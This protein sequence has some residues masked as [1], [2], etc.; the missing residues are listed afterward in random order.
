MFHRATDRPGRQT[1]RA[2]PWR[3]SIAFPSRH[4]AG[5]RQPAMSISPSP[6]SSPSAGRCTGAD[7]KLISTAFQI[8]TILADCSLAM[9]MH[10]R[11]H[12]KRASGRRVSLFKLPFRERLFLAQPAVQRE[13]LGHLEHLTTNLPQLR[14]IRPLLERLRDPSGNDAHL[15]LFHPAR[16]QRRRSDSN[17]AGLHWRIRV[18]GDRILID[19]DSRLSQ[20]MLCLGAQHSLLK[21]VD[22]HHMRV[23]SAGDDAIALSG[24]RLC[25]DLCVG[26]DLLS[27]GRE[28]R[29]LRLFESHGLRRNDVHQRTTLLA[30]KDAAINA[31]GELLTA[32]NQATA[33]ST[34][35]FV[36]CRGYDVCVRNGRWMHAAGDEAGEVGHVQHEVGS[37][38]VSDG[39]H[40]G[41]VELPWIGAAAADDDLWLLALRGGLELVVVNDFGVFAN[42]IADDAVEFAGEVEFVA[43]G[44]MAAVG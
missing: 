7:Y 22:Q 4:Q 11:R 5:E 20:G 44:E 14:S 24:D 18:I 25:E 39:A 32:E 35:G 33:R 34:Q 42:L 31:C 3:S 43:V 27:I 29:L 19:R 16:G 6:Y 15:R 36:G 17:A 9:P 28:L 41:E 13:L 2:L 37:Y 21:D 10:Q 30:R 38:F 12:A 23:R 40:A 26:D 8:R 1:S